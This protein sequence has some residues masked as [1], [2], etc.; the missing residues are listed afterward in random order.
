MIQTVLFNTV[1]EEKGSSSS[2]C[3]YDLLDMQIRNTFDG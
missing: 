2:S 1:E 3:V